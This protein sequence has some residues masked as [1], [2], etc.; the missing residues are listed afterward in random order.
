[1]FDADNDICKDC[2]KWFPAVADQEEIYCHECSK[3]GDAE[4]AIYHGAPACGDK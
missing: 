3:A 4:T 2:G 1:M